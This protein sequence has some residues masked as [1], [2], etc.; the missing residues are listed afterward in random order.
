MRRILLTLLLLAGCSPAPPAA[1]STPTGP[2]TPVVVNEAQPGERFDLEAA[3]PKTGTVLVE[4][5]SL[6]CPPC[7]Q[8]APLLERLAQ[9][10]PE[11]AIRKVNID[12]KGAA[13]I[14]FQSPVAQ[15]YGI[16]SVPRFAVY[17]NGAKKMEGPAAKDQV[18]T[19]MR[20]TGVAQ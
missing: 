19:W 5:Y 12:R 13:G 18:R 4:Y 1:T 20:E 7:L 14:D 2:A 8:M 16:D 9:T 10:K 6:N 3:L 15:Q 17:E 11:L